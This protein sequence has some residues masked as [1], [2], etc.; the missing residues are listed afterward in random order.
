MARIY[1]LK[2]AADF[3]ALIDVPSQYRDPKALV[4]S[5]ESLRMLHTYMIS[6]IPYETLVLHYSRDRQV[7]LDPQDLFDKIVGCGRGRGGYCLENNLLFLFML[8]DLGFQVYPVGTKS[9]NRVDG[10]PQGHFQGWGHIVLIVT[11]SDSSRWVSDVCFGGDGLTQ[12]MQLVEGSMIRN[13]GTQDARLIRD[14]IPGQSSRAPEL[15][16]WQYQCRNS[17]DRPW[18]AFYSF[19]DRVEWLPADVSVVNCFTSASPDSAAVT[20]VCAVKFLRRDVSGSSKGEDMN[21]QAQEIFG[22][23]ICF[24]AFIKEDLGWK[25]TVVQECRSEEARVDALRHWFGSTLTDEERSSVKGH[26]TEL[27]QLRSPL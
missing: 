6:A 11:F 25:T 27:G 13:M 26:V 9:R 3:L 2:Q 20:S 21:H 5:P 19:S 15:K 12:P 22:K 10:I 4:P 8:R 23:R 7:R 14:F 24:N 16:M 1:S 18:T 17:E